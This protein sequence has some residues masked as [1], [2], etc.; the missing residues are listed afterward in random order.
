M[1]GYSNNH[2]LVGTSTRSPSQCCVLGTGLEPV[3][4]AVKA[5]C[6]T[7]LAN[8]TSCP[9]QRLRL[10][11]AFIPTNSYQLYN[12]RGKRTNVFLL[13]PFARL[14]AGLS[15]CFADTA[16]LFSQRPNTKPCPSTVRLTRCFIVPLCVL[17]SKPQFP[18]WLHSH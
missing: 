9:L 4:S 1:V 3:I 8:P 5:R 13:F 10:T 12:S 6:L 16:P 11:G 18:P 15:I 17:L 7:N 14:H 2:Q